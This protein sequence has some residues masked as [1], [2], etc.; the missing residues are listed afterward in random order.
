MDDGSYSFLTG[1]WSGPPGFEFGIHFLWYF[2][3]KKMF[4]KDKEPVYADLFHIVFIISLVMISMSHTCSIY[5]KRKSVDMSLRIDDIMRL[6][7]A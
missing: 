1:L 3:R 7:D 4:S 2:R 6:F 5:I